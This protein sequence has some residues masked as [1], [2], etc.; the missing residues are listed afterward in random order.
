MKSQKT[1]TMIE[2]DPL[3]IFVFIAVILFCAVHCNAQVGTTGGQQPP[4]T[5]TTTFY[6]HP[7]HAAQHD[8]AA[9]EDVLEGGVTVA[10]GERPVT[11]FL[12]EPKP[13]V[14]LGDIA[15]Y[16]R[17]HKYIPMKEGGQ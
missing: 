1:S 7:I 12:E 13:E 5:N 16:Y 4:N 15:R 6:E 10:H 17:T 11:D 2:I 3:M 8:L 14:P 9:R